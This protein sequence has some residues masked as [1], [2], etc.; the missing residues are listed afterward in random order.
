MMNKNHDIV[1]I[2]TTLSKMQK[3]FMSPT[4]FQQQKKPQSGNKNKSL[5][6]NKLKYT[7]YDSKIT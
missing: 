7:M 1:D 6:K 4:S 3:T 5:E 2:D